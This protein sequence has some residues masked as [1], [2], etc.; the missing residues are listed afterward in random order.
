MKAI[1]IKRVFAERIMDG[2][3]KIEYRT[4]PTKHRGALVI[5]ASGP[6]G[7]LLGVVEVV[8]CNWN[9]KDQVWEWELSNPRRL[10]T[11]I[12][13]KGRLMLWDVPPE[14][15]P[16]LAALLAHPAA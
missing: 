3:K 14:H 11:P 16:A 1:S 15:A 13:C 7:A 5:H 12:G 10:A 6:G 9:D 8:G 2:T 4:W